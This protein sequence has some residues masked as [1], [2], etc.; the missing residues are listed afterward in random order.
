MLLSF[1]FERRRTNAI[2]FVGQGTNAYILWA[3]YLVK[4]QNHAIHPL[5]PLMIFEWITLFYY[6]TQLYQQIDKIRGIERETGHGVTVE[7]D[8]PA[9]IFLG[10]DYFSL[11]KRVNATHQY[12]LS[13]ERL[14]KLMQLKLVEIKASE[15][16]SLGSWASPSSQAITGQ[17]PPAAALSGRAGESSKMI[18]EMYD[19]IS[20]TIAVTLADMAHHDRACSLQLSV[21]S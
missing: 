15:I 2:V 20:R 12:S 18:R 16:L 1:D 13:I 19:S 6:R 21:V 17:E 3:K 14:V 5:L 11:T 8:D 9:G 4:F 7:T 10:L